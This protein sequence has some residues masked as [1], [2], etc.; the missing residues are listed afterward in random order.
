MT[1]S[2]R[3]K[4]HEA[5]EALRQDLLDEDGPRISTMRNYRFAILVYDP[6]E[7]F[8]LRQQIQW[9]TSLLKSQGWNVGQIFLNQL[10]LKRLKQED[11]SVI[12][13][14]ISRE[15]RLY[16]RNPDRALNHLKE[17]IAPYVE[18]ADGIARD[19]IEE[20]DGFVDA[21]PIEADRTV[22]FLR[23]AGA[24]YPFLRSSALL[25]HLDGKTRNLPV[26]L[27]YPGERRDKSLSF[28]G[29]L[30]GDRDYRP[31]IYG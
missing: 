4:V 2:L 10:L 7:E 12:D 30:T 9:L 26:V 25:K 22:I 13:N 3:T 20:I 16:Q 5:V 29:E 31:R 21:Q 11:S 19:I 1:V 17:K 14:I 18:G 23:R 28:M 24:L 8:T 6:K 27:F 15:R